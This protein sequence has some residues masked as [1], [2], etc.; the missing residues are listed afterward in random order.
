M[1]RYMARILI[2]ACSIKQNLKYILGRFTE[3][4]LEEWIN[5]SRL[6]NL[7]DLSYSQIKSPRKK[8][9]TRRKKIKIKRKKMKTIRTRKN[10]MLKKRKR[11]RTRKEKW[12]LYFVFHTIQFCRL[13][14]AVFFL[15]FHSVAN[16]HLGPIFV[17]ALSDFPI[18]DLVRDWVTM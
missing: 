6:L 15:V 9:K 12:V 4:I 8:R 18:I 10:L 17:G 2:N 13:R 7:L 14:N 3:K 16:C 11:T 5:L 1:P